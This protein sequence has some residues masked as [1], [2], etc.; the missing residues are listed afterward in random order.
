M[1]ITKY[2]HACLIL[3]KDNPDV[4]IFSTRCYH[5]S[6]KALKWSAYS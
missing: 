6:K 5:C 3:E 2:E 4:A 1:K